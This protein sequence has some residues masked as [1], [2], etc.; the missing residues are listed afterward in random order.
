M[1]FLYKHLDLVNAK[2][3]R[4]ETW[5]LCS[6]IFTELVLKIKYRDKSNFILLYK[7]TDNLNLFRKI[8]H[9]GIIINS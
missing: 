7:I 1:C 5:Y 8:C 3:Y 2:S 9:Y 6:S 4:H